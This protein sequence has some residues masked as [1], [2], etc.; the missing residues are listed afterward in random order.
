MY[1]NDV[2][3]QMTLA[4]ESF[5]LSPGKTDPPKSKGGHCPY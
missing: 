5:E 1:G 2:Q 4:K 3:R